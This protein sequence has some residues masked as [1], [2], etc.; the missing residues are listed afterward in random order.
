LRD[1]VLCQHIV[2]QISREHLR[3]LLKKGH[4]VSNR[5]QRKL[6]SHDPQR[7]A[8][9]ARIRRIW[10]QLPRRG[11]LL[12]FDVKPVAVKAYGGRRYTSAKKLVLPRAQKTRGGSISSS[13]MMPF[14][15]AF[16]GPAILAKVRNYVCQFMRPRATLVPESAALGGA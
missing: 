15:G 6:I 5:V 11:R 13:R 1:Y 10:R 14:P 16:I 9:M 3:R 4:S 12:F 7:P 2:T 8:I